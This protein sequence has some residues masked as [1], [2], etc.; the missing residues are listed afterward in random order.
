VTTDF[1]GDD[2][3]ANGLVIQPDGKLVAAGSAK[4]SRSQD[5][6]LAGYTPTGLWT[7]PSAPAAR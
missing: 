6:A 1:G 4:V 7:R 3:V 5:F 2:D